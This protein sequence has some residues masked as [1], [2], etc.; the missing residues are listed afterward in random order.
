VEFD[1]SRA[2]AISDTANDGLLE[3]L[4]ELPERQRA[5]LVLHYY[6][7]YPTSDISDIVGISSAA[8]RM[9]LTRGRR[10]LVKVLE[11]GETRD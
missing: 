6:A 11:K 5:C 7:G 3:E 9:S 1:G 10:G 2:Q 8:V 4:P